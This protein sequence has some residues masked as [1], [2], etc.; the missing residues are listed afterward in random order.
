MEK[1]DIPSF[2]TVLDR[3]CRER[4]YLAFVE[5]PA[6]PEVRRYVLDHI[7]K[8]DVQIVAARGNEIVGWCDII[9]LELPGFGHA[10]RLGMGLAGKFR[11][12]GIGSNLVKEALRLARERGLRR[13][14]LEVFASNPKA[15]RLYE[16]F[17]F[18]MEGRKVRA[19]YLD[20]R[21]D[22]V[23]LMGLLL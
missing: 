2:R 5:A 22:D 1:K 6:L 20:E 11:G 9:R 16:R 15:I 10:G 23:V 18:S 4:K 8:K 13:I 17:G 7:A 12:I 14:E 3:V 19:R 21:F